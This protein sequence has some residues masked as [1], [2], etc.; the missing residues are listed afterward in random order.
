MY[1]CII[2]F[3]Y[4]LTH[5]LKQACRLVKVV[6][7]THN[8]ACYSTVG[9]VVGVQTGMLLHPQHT[10]MRN[11]TLSYRHVTVTCDRTHFPQRAV[12]TQL[13]DT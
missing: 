4:S 6:Y 12:G 2:A 8:A 13:S 10:S 1:G 5:C 7:T 3:A 11:G 9:P